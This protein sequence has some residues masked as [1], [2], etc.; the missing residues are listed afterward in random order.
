MEGN[1][2][3]KFRCWLLQ[4]VVRLFS[5]LFVF[6]TTFL[7]PKKE[8]LKQ[9]EQKKKQIGKK[10]S[11]H[12]SRC[13][14]FPSPYFQ[15]VSSPA[16][17]PS[18]RKAISLSFSLFYSFSFLSLSLSLDRSFISFG[19]S[20][21]PPPHSFSLSFDRAFFSVSPSRQC[22][23]YYSCFSADIPPSLVTGRKMSDH[24][25]PARAFR[26][27]ISSAFRDP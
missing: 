23:C 12:Y 3:N 17:P 19:F 5:P 13:L 15:C 6:E 20:S 24:L 7:H 8:Q 25:F 16:T 9:K 1:H 10:F 18:L 26:S 22:C 4:A 11:F 27:S 14:F 2:W 21:S